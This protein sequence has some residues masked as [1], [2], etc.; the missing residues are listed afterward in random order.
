VA[1]LVVFPGSSAL[2]G[3]VNG[4]LI[5]FDAPV[6]ISGRVVE[7]VHRQHAVIDQVHADLKATIAF[8]PDPRRSSVHRSPAG[9]GRHRH[10]PAQPDHCARQNRLLGP[11]PAT[12]PTTHWPWRR[13]W[14]ELFIPLRSVCPASPSSRMA[15]L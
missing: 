11:T 12:A 13:E 4:S 3:T 9:P 6:T 15:A 1:D 10:H 7:A 5:A 8:Q 14:T 2:T